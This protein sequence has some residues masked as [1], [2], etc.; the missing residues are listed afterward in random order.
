MLPP[1]LWRVAALWRIGLRLAGLLLP[2][3]LALVGVIRGRKK[4]ALSG[5]WKKI[6]PVLMGVMVLLNWTVLVYFIV[7]ERVG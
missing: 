6:S 7:N 3:A 2:P 1:V 4:G 5:N